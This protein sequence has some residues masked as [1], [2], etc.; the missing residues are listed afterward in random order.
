[1]QSAIRSGSTEYSVG[2]IGF[3]SFPFIVGLAN[4]DCIR[5][6]YGSTRTSEL[7]LEFVEAVRSVGFACFSAVV[8]A[9]SENLFAS[10]LPGRLVFRNLWIYSSAERRIIGDFFPDEPLEL[11]PFFRSLGPILSHTRELQLIGYSALN[12]VLTAIRIKY[13]HNVC[14]VRS[15]FPLWFE[16]W[17]ENCRD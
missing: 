12:P 3:Y 5:R 8:Q 15:Q 17:M 1:M 7:N 13:E 10:T 6:H 9:S 4:R 11:S 14:S 16:R 2:S